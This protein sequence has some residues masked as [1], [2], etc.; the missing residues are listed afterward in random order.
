R[1]LLHVLNHTRI[2]NAVGFTISNKPSGSEDRM[3]ESSRDYVR[4]FKNEIPDKDSII[5]IYC[6]TGNNGGDGAA[7]AR[8]LKEDGYDR[9]SVKLVRFSER[10]TD[11]FNTN[12][13]RLQLTGIPI[14]EIYTTD[15]LPEEN[16]GILIDALI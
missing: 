14:S 15:D 13:R 10:L 7:I 4:V 1:R 8:L 11:D 2:R 6:G 5:S 12:L 3:D 16:A 9:L